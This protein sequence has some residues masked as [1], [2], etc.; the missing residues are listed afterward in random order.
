M[1]ENPDDKM[2]S[3]QEVRAI[4]P[5][6]VVLEAFEYFRTPTLDLPSLIRICI[7]NNCGNADVAQSLLSKMCD[8]K[9][10]VW[11][12]SNGVV[13]F[14]RVGFAPGNRCVN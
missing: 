11:S 7:V 14:T 6:E 1:S 13:Y 10:L 4:T 2:G 8:D 5:E 12:K 9:R 3:A